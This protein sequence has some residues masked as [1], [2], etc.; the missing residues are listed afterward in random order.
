MRRNDANGSLTPMID[1]ACRK[2]AWARRM[3]HSYAYYN[4]SGRCVRAVTEL[5]TTREVTRMSQRKHERGLRRAA[6]RAGTGNWLVPR[7]MSACAALR[8]CKMKEKRPERP[9]EMLIGHTYNMVW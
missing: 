8:V 9:L 5:L 7:H 3:R 6:R 4:A 2:I 1:A